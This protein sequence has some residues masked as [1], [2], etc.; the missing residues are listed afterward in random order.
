MA[1]GFDPASLG[2]PA[3]TVA[4]FSGFKYFPFFGPSGY[5][6]VG[7]SGGDFQAGNTFF[8]QGAYTKTRGKHSLHA[9]CDVRAYRENTLPTNSPAGSYSF[10]HTYTTG[11]VDNS[12]GGPVGQSLA[13]MLLG[14][15]TGGSID[16][17]ATSANQTLFPAIYLHDDFK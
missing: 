16:R 11:P 4:L 3:P 14:L 8:L 10:A 9:G 12:S 6:T 17:V 5:G 7:A 15:P 1:A 13:S 2:F